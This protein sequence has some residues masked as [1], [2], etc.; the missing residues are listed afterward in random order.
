MS[1][2]PLISHHLFVAAVKQRRTLRRVR[3]GVS[4]GVASGYRDVRVERVD[5]G[6]PMPLEA[7]SRVVLFLGRQTS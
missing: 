4:S 3:R 1:S 5:F 6:R 2:S 7:P